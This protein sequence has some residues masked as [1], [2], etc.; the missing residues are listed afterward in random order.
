MSQLLRYIPELCSVTPPQCSDPPHWNPLFLSGVFQFACYHPEW[1]DNRCR[2]WK[3]RNQRR[4]I[5]PRFWIDG[6]VQHQQK[7]GNWYLK[8]KKEIEAITINTRICLSETKLEYIAVKP[9][10]S[11]PS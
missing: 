7:T 11:L 6:G 8:H 1:E 5:R 10:K 2:W 9:Q 4:R 3:K